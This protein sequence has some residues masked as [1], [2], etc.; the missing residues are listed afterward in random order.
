MFYTNETD[1]PNIVQT[2][3]GKFFFICFLEVSRDY[4]KLVN[5]LAEKIQS[6]YRLFQKFNKD[7]K[8]FKYEK[9][10]EDIENYGKL[11]KYADSIIEYSQKLDSIAKANSFIPIFN[12][13]LQEEYYEDRDNFNTTLYYGYKKLVETAQQ[14]NLLQVID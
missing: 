14:C 6:Q 2:D 1:V 12:F 10:S 7:N 9:T 13:D 8:D 3:N 11:K 4:L 5:Y